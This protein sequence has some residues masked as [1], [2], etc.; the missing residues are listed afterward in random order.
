MK[1]LWWRL[2]LLGMAGVASLL[3]MPIEQ[4]VSVPVDPMLLRSLAIIQPALL[5]LAFVA[6]GAWA[7]PKVGLD[8]PLIRAWIDGRPIL[9]ILRRQFPL[10]LLTGAAVSLIILL[11]AA[12]LRAQVESGPILDFKP[13]LISRMLYGGIA[14]ELITR[15]GLMSFFVWTAWRLRGGGDV[16]PPWCYWA[17]AA[18]AAL[19]FAAGHLPIL[20]SAMPNPPLMLLTA[21][22]LGNAVPGLLFGWLFWRRG[23]EAAMI[24][25][26]LAH[27]FA[28]VPQLVG[29]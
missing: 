24:A 10:A 29:V 14:E 3:L 19:L 4:L 5:V 20:F 1:A 22:L 9:P 6:L 26:A 8:S 13:P 21:T 17:G 27:L 7:A 15:W 12:L 25:H 11:Y 18:S 16:V 23:L 2:S 28:V